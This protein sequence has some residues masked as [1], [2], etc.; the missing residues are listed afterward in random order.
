MIWFSLV[1]ISCGCILQTLIIFTIFTIGNTYSWFDNFYNISACVVCLKVA[2]QQFSDIFS[3]DILES[4]LVNY[5]WWVTK[6]LMN[7]VWC[8]WFVIWRLLPSRTLLCVISFCLDI[9]VLFVD[10][11][12]GIGIMSSQNL[13]SFIYRQKMARDYWGTFS[14]Q[15]HYI[16]VT[17]LV[18][19]RW[20]ICVR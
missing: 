7:I 20:L 19:S 2:F 5:R 18:Q 8:F 3:N 1:V 13:S 11:W 12:K 6:S 16:F 17:N 10:D 15:N 9:D 14:W 4:C